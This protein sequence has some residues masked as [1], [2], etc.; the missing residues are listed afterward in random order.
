MSDLTGKSIVGFSRSKS[1]E[2]FTKAINPATGEKLEPQYST[3]SS[4]EVTK[5]VDLAEKAFPVYSGLPASKRAE[6]LRRIAELIEAAGDAIAERGVQ[7][8]GLPEAR[9]R[10]ETGRTT[11][12]LRMFA[13]LIEEGSW[14]DARIEQA[15]PDR[16]PLPKPDLRSMKRPLGPVV[17]FCASNFP[18]AFSV[19][20]G[21]T[22]SALAAGCPVLV[23]AH[24]SHPGVAEIVGNCVEQ[25]ARDTQMPEGVFSL[26]FGGGRSVGVAMVESPAVQAVG[27]TG[28]R[29]G[30]TALMKAAAERKQPIPVYAEMSAVNPV[31]LLPEALKER[32]ESI[33]EGM[34]TSL[35]MGVG[36]FCT[37]PGLVFLPKDADSAFK[38]KLAGLVAE[39]AGA[40]MLNA[41]IAKAFKES[42]AAIAAIDGVETVATA[43]DAG[44]N[45]GSPA[46]FSVSVDKFL[47]NSDLEAEM[48][49]PATLIVEGTVEEIEKALARLEGQLVGTV[50]GTEEE[51]KNYTSL[52]KTLEGRCGRLVFNG[53]PTGVDV[54]HAM[55]HGGPYPAT[56]DG[57]S[58]SVGTMAIDRFCRPVAWQAFPESQL[59]E[60]LHNGNPLKIWRLVDGERSRDAL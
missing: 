10:G 17:V 14:V 13:A 48:F 28:S 4:D 53:F 59:P 32:G 55:V 2:P 20:G 40:C 35:T 38:Q 19:A 25:A 1:D 23:K 15:Q 21:D 27:F 7:E 39:A 50:H 36:Q 52:V 26:I 34:L 43:K 57:R 8:T 46:V 9:M 3:A 49:G 11:G 18:L 22:A 16:Q 5:A 54:C 33:A 44:E 58:T 45:C 41:G 60:E 24:H 29:S 12:Q 42:T 47:D 31:V 37:N 30:G 51:I 6:F 56:A